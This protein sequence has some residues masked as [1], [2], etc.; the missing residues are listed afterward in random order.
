[1]FSMRYGTVPIVRA[2][3][4]LIDTVDD[5]ADAEG[6]GF[7][8]QE[9]G[10]SALLAAISRALQVYADKAAWLKLQQNGM[11]RDFS[12]GKSAR[13]YLEIYRRLAGIRPR[14]SIPVQ[15]DVQAEGGRDK[16]G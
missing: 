2:T 7:V 3:G 10:A 12:W 4:G 9:A 8:F 13:S 5:Y 15:N 1:M 16:R 6:T 14:S 11:A